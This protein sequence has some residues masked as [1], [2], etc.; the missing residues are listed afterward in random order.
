MEV[1]RGGLV[2]GWEGGEGGPPKTLSDRVEEEQ[3]G[4]FVFVFKK[5]L[6]LCPSSLLASNE[7]VQCCRRQRPLHYLSARTFISQRYQAPLQTFLD[8]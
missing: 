2:L 8:F 3:P 4:V 5:S 1:R 6:N 7:L